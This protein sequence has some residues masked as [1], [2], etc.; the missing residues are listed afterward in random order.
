M[1]SLVIASLRHTL[2]LLYTPTHN[3][4]DNCVGRQVAGFNVYSYIHPHKMC[5]ATAL[6]ETGSSPFNTHTKCV[7]QLL[8]GLNTLYPKETSLYLVNTH[9]YCV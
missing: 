4:C 9:T 8:K 3:V 2:L 7:W 5:V 1:L 6:G